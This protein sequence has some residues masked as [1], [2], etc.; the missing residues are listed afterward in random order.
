MIYLQISIGR[1]PAECS[2]VLNHV[3]GRILG[4]GPAA[5][6]VRASPHSAVISLDGAEAELYARQWLGTILWVCEDPLRPN[7]KRKN[8][9]LGVQLIEV[10]AMDR[11]LIRDEDLK[12]ETKRASGKGGQHVNKT[13]SSVRLTHI[14]T[15]LTVIS[16]DER[17]QHRNKTIALERLRRALQDK[18][19]VQM[20]LLEKMNWS[21]HNKLE[22]GNPI[23]V[24]EGKDFVERK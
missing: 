23:R 21:H 10:P 22:R 4:E 6:L 13:E 12:W 19:Q 11:I 15:G 7:R 5:R 2:F 14:P 16:E 1:G 20:A 18:N 24:F 8:W 17:S 3:V 9:Y